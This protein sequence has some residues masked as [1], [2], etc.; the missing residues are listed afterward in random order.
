MSQAPS[1]RNRIRVLTIWMGEL[2]PYF[3]GWLR[4]AQA[5]YSIDFVLITDQDPDVGN[6]NVT[7]MHAELPTLLERFSC[8]FCRPVSFSS[9]V[10][11]CGLRPLYGLAF[12]DL[13]RGYDFWGYCDID[14]AFGDIRAFLTDMVLDSYDRFYTRGHFCLYRNDDATN[15][16]FELPGSVYTLNDVMQGEYNYPF[17][18]FCGINRICL[19]N[20]DAVRWYTSDDFADC[21]MRAPF[22]QVR[23][24]HVNYEHQLAWW[25]D[26]RVFKAGITSDGAV[27]V[28]EFV[29]FH[30][31]HK[32]GADERVRSGGAR[33]YF[34]TE[35]GLVE[36]RI[37]GVPTVEELMLPKEAIAQN[38]GIRPSGL[39]LGHKLVSFV[40]VPN[41]V[42]VVRA[43]ELMCAL[44]D[45]NPPYNDYRHVIFPRK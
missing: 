2:P 32:F 12:S 5:N 36:K 15:H 43:K 41:R 10:K 14:L 29:Y 7:V 1:C 24:P 35:Q 6:E 25:E 37:P 16:L 27:S 33:G 21:D 31:R 42:K 3:S 23:P 45:E 40:R 13:L 20:P 34:I 38:V 11:L 39:R 17:D 28:D 30:W 26:G 19:K 18:E 4:S 44:F 8:A 9:P 22:I